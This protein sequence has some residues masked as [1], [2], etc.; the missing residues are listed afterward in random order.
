MTHFIVAFAFLQWSGT[1]PTVSPEHAFESGGGGRL[2]RA[3][4]K[5][6][7]TVF[8]IILVVVELVSSFSDCS[9]YVACG[10]ANGNC[11][12]FFF[13]F[14]CAWESGLLEGGHTVSLQDVS[15]LTRD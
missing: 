13:L 15:S 5:P 14:L 11:G 7:L 8:S 1:E 9:V 2:Q 4:V 3:N 10:I 12:M 6:T